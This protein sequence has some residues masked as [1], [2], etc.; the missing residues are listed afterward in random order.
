[1]AINDILSGLLTKLGLKMTEQEKIEKQIAIQEKNAYALEKELASFH[2]EIDEME[3]RIASLRDKANAAKT[4]AQRDAYMAELAPEVQKL[5]RHKEKRDITQDKLNTVNVVL[6][7]LEL[8]LKDETLKVPDTIEVGELID[9]KKIALAEA[10]DRNR[11]VANLDS[12]TYT[13]PQ[14]EDTTAYDKP[15]VNNADLMAEV[16]ELLKTFEPTTADETEKRSEDA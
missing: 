16:N 13:K 3:R 12:T 9:D 7:N 8:R 14:Y 5:K 2:V 10:E 6:H 11:E 4:A 15:Q 1:M